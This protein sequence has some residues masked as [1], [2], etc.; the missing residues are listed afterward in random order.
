MFD[1]FY[2]YTEYLVYLKR[3]H[4]CSFFLLFDVSSL[5]NHKHMQTKIFLFDII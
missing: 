2:K 5:I 1:R 3:N 4:F